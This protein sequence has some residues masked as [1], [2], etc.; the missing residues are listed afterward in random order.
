MNKL[1]KFSLSFETHEK[2]EPF[3]QQVE[4]RIRAKHRQET[5]RLKELLAFLVV[6][7]TARP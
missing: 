1:Q 4:A 6:L 5:Q 2:D 3:F 7:T